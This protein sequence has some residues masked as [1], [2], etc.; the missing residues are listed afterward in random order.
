[1]GI[2]Y[3][4]DD[5][6]LG[7]SIVMY[8]GSWYGDRA[9]KIPSRDFTLSNPVNDNLHNGLRMWVC[10]CGSHLFALLL[11]GSSL[12]W[13]CLKPYTWTRG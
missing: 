3:M 4:G 7:K 8:M 12:C 2:I 9:V 11:D 5:M 10:P 1:V 6:F 13:Q